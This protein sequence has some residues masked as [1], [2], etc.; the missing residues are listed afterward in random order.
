LE[1]DFMRDILFIVIRTAVWQKKSC[2]G[3]I[4]ATS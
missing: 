4:V 1:D 2:E 3:A